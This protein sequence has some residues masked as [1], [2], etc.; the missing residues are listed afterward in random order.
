MPAALLMHSPQSAADLVDRARA[1][2]P[3]ALSELYARHGRALMALAFRLTRSRD[4]AEDVLHDVFLGLPEALRRYEERGT[5]ESWLKRVTARVALSRLRS[6]DRKHE[7]TL[8]DTIPSRSAGDQLDSL[9]VQ[10]AIDALPDS[11][12]VVFI[13]RE[14]EGYT[15][16][17]IA[18][19]LN[20]SSGASE[21]R[22]HRAIRALRR[23]LGAGS[24]Q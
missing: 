8:E 12:R 14:V 19:L 5:L 16:A 24:D 20:I 1:G 15:H 17:E 9:A 4:D 13:L 23:S 18:D 11:L 22:L 3:D 10:R 2:N 21:V 6:R 7:V